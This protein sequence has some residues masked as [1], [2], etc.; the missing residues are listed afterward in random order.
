VTEAGDTVLDADLLTAGRLDV[1][2]SGGVA[3]IT[4][5]APQVRNAQL[6]AT[7][8]ALAHIGSRIRDGACGDVRVVVV[9]GAGTSFSAGLDRSAFTGDPDSLLTTLARQPAAVADETIA[10][11]QGGFGWLTNP[12]FVSV[13][14]VQGHAVG[15]GFQL[16]LACDLIVAAEDAQF[17]MAEVTLGLVPDLGGTGRLVRAVGT[18]R[19]LEICATGRRV[20]AAEAVRIGLAVT[21]VPAAQLDDAVADLVAALTSPDADT[22]RA[23]TKLITGCADRTVTQQLAAERYE[24]VTRLQALAARVQSGQDA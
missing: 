23:V 24:Q 1:T 21:A 8:S 17:A 19:A 12:L 3:T 7:W 10:G 13:A 15:A 9:R 22:V 16:A 18:A 5:N 20:G 6:P 4:L 11:F 2:I 14:A